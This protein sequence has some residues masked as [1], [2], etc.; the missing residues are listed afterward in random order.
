[1]ENYPS[2]ASCSSPSDPALK[3]SSVDDAPSLLATLF[4][5]LS[6]YMEII[7]M[8]LRHMCECSRHTFFFF[9]FFFAD[10]YVKPTGKGL[11]C[12]DQA[13]AL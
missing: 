5:F 6:S 2:A 10:L 12:V 8:K 7:S 3:A 11:G 4:I 1:M 13:D 9:F